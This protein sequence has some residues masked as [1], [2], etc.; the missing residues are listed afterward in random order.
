MPAAIP[1]SVASGSVL[2]ARNDASMAAMPTCAWVGL[3]P[4]L[5]ASV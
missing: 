5:I 4:W 2:P 3:A 1:S